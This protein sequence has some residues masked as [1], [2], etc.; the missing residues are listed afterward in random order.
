MSIEAT[1]VY[2]GNRDWSGPI[3]GGGRKKKR[4]GSFQIRETLLPNNI[5]PICLDHLLNQG[6]THD[7]SC[8]MTKL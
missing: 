4:Q 8:I 7:L 2:P 3:D 5:F 6:P 1:K